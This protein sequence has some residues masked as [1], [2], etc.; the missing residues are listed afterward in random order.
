M[1]VKFL[2]PLLGLV[3]GIYISSEIFGGLTFS[4]IIL[5]SAL[6]SWCVIT[7]VSK[8]P[9]KNYK[10]A[11]LHHVWI[12]LLFVAIGSLDFSFRSKP[13]F[14][15]PQ[16]SGKLTITGSIEAERN[17]SGGDSFKVHVLELK[18]SLG[19][20]LSARNLN[21]YLKTDGFS[22]NVGDIITFKTTPQFIGKGDNANQFH[23][24][25]R[26]QGIAATANVKYQNI[27]KIGELSSLFLY[28]QNLRDELIIKIEKSNLERETGDFLISI[29][30]GDK[31]FLSSETRQTLSSAGMAHV[32]ALSGMHV[33]IILSILL[34]VL[35]PLSLAGYNKTR[36]VIAL[37]LIWCYVLLTGMAPSTVRAAIMATLVLFSYLIE[38]KN[39]ALNSLLFAVLIILLIDPLAL[40]NIGLQLSF[41]CV[42]SILIFTSK[43]NPVEHHAHP[44][45][46]KAVNLILITLITTFSTWVV[47][48]YYFKSVPLLFLPANIIL[49]P[50]LPCFV[51]LGIIY[52]VG[53]STGHDISI[54][55]RLLDL[56]HDLYIHTADI[57]SLSGR[58]NLSAS[59]PSESV[60][61]WLSGVF[62]LAVAL[63]ATR[64][65]VKKIGFATSTAVLSLSVLLIFFIKE[66]E[67]WSLK[68]MHSFTKMEAQI[69]NNGNYVSLNFPRNTISH[70]EHERFTI[71]AID[72]I[73]KEEF[74]G[75]ITTDKARADYLLIGPNAD[76]DQV[77][78]IINC[79]SFSKIIFHPGVGKKKRADI[80]NSVNES[81]WPD[82]YSL[83]E[84]GSLEIP[85]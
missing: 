51:L 22:G 30:L 21:I 74:V 78:E 7:Y 61:L 66:E 28:F 5:A 1:K 76:T 32:L 16:G 41:L 35:F 26:H 6:I 37:L 34:V 25:L 52:T 63:Y 31:T 73:L 19:N 68:F 75:K 20:K 11:P 18:D 77:A 38:R 33:A 50:L 69:A 84:E 53:L 56:Y 70:T 82:L 40:W 83:A 64:N 57:L 10:Y 2:S 36:Y 48:A 12:L 47:V 9:V 45:L 14:A 44:R 60:F 67:T 58:S 55:A 79:N 62:I 43:L 80:F 8:D 15:P 49:L 81:I 23:D 24:Y 4:L 46:Y 65:K 59:I 29:L 42:A 71:T 85:I 13:Y 17:Y 3:L 39:A 54:I 27:T 72:K